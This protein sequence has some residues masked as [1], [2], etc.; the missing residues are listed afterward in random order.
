[1]IPHLIADIGNSRIKLALFLGDTIIRK[2]IFTD[3]DWNAFDP[4]DWVDDE[5]FHLILS[6]VR[7]AQPVL[8]EWIHAGGQ[9]FIMDRS[10]KLPFGIDYQTPE[11]LGADRLANAA[12]AMRHGSSALVIDCGSC[13]TY[14]TLEHNML[15]GGAISP[16][17]HMRFKALNTFTG[18]LPLIDATDFEVRFP[19]KSTAESILAGVIEGA[20]AEAD[21]FIRIFSSKN[22][23]GRVILTGGDAPVLAALL[24]CP[25]F[26]DPDHTLTGLHEILKFNL[27]A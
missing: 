3:E 11:T 12:G 7:E 18:N 14:T 8:P 26:A 22:A 10:L 4:A 24:K 5:P 17:L 27:E 1:M 6:S 19:G 23:D 2:D 16:G 20:H 13:L 9:A 15:T 21:Y 25:I